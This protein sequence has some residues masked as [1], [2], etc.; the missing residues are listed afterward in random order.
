MPSPFPGMDPYLEDP[1]HWQGVHRQI[2]SEIQADLNSRLQP[3]YFVAVEERVYISDA[4]EIREPY[5]RVIE[6]TTQQVVTVLELLSPMN[7]S[8]ASPG[9]KLYMAKRSEILASDTNWVELDLLRL[10]EP[11]IPREIYPKCEYTVHISR[12]TQRPKSIVLPI[13]IH[14]R[15][16]VI[17]IPL[18]GTGNDTELDLQS[19]VALIY[20]RGDFGIRFDYS[21]EP[22]PPLSHELAK[23]ANKHLMQR[24]A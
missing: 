19:I 24:K 7:K 9:R 1:A 22:Q 6:Q 2:I 3:R 11:V 13:R 20:D 4:G 18:N 10:G 16:P 12:V 15:L 23:W 21:K 17:P 14:E 8:G 5:L